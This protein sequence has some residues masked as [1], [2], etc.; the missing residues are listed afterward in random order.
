MALTRDDILGADD[1]PRIEVDV[2]EWGGPVW[3]RTMT[4]T[5]KDAFEDSILEKRGKGKNATYEMTLQNIRAKL[6]VRTLCDADGERL[7]TNKDLNA[8]AG[9]NGGVMTRL[10]AEAQTL[11]GLDADDIEELAGN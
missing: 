11:N 5:E 4:A 10:F 9:K 2:P 6:L 3:V 1:L 8:L 7:F